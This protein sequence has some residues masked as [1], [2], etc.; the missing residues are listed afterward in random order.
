MLSVLSASEPRDTQD[1]ITTIINN[2]KHN[3]NDII[4]IVIVIV[5]IVI[6][7]ILGALGVRASGALRLVL[8]APLA[9]ARYLLSVLSSLLTL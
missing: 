1:V 7:I 2:T 8:T 3:S 5:V 4:F 9:V 6:I